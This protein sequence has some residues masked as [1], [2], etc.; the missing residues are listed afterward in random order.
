MK[1]KYI[2]FKLALI[3]LALIL[4]VHQV[5][6]HKMTISVPPFAPFAFINTSAKIKSVNNACS[7]VSIQIIKK[8]LQN[9][10]IKFEQINYPYA[11]ILRSLT[12]GKLDAALIFKN[13]VVAKSVNYIGPVT[14][15]KVV[16]LTK[17]EVTI[18]NYKQLKS[19]KK[20]AVIRNAHYQHHFDQDNSLNKFGVESYNQALKM[21]KNNR[22]SAVVG[23]LEGLDYAL[24]Q[25]KMPLTWLVNAF[26]LG[27]KSWW[28][29][30]SK[31]SRYNYLI[32]QLTK[33]AQRIYQADIN[34]ITY[35][36]AIK[37]CKNK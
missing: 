30:I 25:Q 33:T 1:Y 20:I 8:L 4:P 22:V 5:Y 26:V 17:P 10:D 14:T 29:H 3:F 21:L 36:N 23:S 7:G 9:T 12:S 35:Q 18:H 2:N 19:L 37:N 16:V 24:R 27:K 13:D 6:A 28:L 32:P 15:S 11:R 34:Y 31:K